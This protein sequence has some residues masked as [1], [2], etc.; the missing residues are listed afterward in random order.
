MNPLAIGQEIELTC[1]TQSSF[2]ASCNALKEPERVYGQPI[3][4][5]LSAIVLE[6][7][8]ASAQQ[9]HA[10]LL[11]ELMLALCDPEGRPYQHSERNQVSHAGLSATPC[12]GSYVEL[13]SCTE[14]AFDNPGAG[15]VC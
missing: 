6:G 14:D 1:G 5:N 4:E 2:G 11:R 12:T 8:R 10:L 13:A 9:K 7:G 3:T 15:E